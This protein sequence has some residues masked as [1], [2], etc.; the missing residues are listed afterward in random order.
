MGDICDVE[1]LVR[2]GVG[3]VLDLS[4]CGYWSLTQRF[5]AEGITYKALD[6][7]DNNRY[8]IVRE[9]FPEAFEFIAAQIKLGR[10][11]LV[12]CWAG[13]NRSPTIVVG[14]LARRQGM[15]L[16]DA[17]RHVMA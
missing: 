4:Q 10:R 11:V 1:A 7:K 13:E 17:F 3:A 15:P 9:V 8:D 5:E 12:N 2:R 6:C 16:V 14:F